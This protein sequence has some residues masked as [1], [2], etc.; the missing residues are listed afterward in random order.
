LLGNL[1]ILADQARADMRKPSEPQE[2][3]WAP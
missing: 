1:S 2:A 3:D